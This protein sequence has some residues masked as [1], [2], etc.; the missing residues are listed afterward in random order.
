MA[1]SGFIGSSHFF[2]TLGRVCLNSGDDSA[3][4]LFTIRRSLS[5]GI[6]SRP[7]SLRLSWFLNHMH[8]VGSS[9]FMS[10]R[11]WTVES[12]HRFLNPLRV[13]GG[14]YDFYRN[15][16]FS[17]LLGRSPNKP[18]LSGV[19]FRNCETLCKFSPRNSEHPSNNAPQYTILRSLRR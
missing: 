10:D 19:A 12:G 14:E 13:W 4:I 6:H 8:V 9:P 1:D 2:T 15:D 5:L 18:D 11:W 3:Q 7:L 16:H 17:H